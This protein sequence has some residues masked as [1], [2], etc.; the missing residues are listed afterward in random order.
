MRNQ[1]LVYFSN[2]KTRTCIFYVFYNVLQVYSV[3]TRV[4][5]LE[6]ECSCVVCVYDIVLIVTISPVVFV[7]N[8]AHLSIFMFY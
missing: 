5:V 2:K 7:T 4:L 3:C 8:L 1:L 6:T